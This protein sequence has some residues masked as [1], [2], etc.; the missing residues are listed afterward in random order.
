MAFIHYANVAQS[1]RFQAR[2]RVALVKHAQT[3]RGVPPEQKLTGEE[4]A[5]RDVLVEQKGH[6]QLAWNIVA[7]TPAQTAMAAAVPG[8]TGPEG[9]N[10]DV[11]GDAITDAMVTSGVS[12]QWPFFVRN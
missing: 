9:V 7:L 1:G 2:V 6:S 3:R 11:V 5:I 12:N 10:Y 4:Q 8:A